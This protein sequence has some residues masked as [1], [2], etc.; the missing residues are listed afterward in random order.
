MVPAASRQAV[1]AKA[2]IAAVNGHGRLIVAVP[3]AVAGANRGIGLA[4]VSGDQCRG[5][6][7]VLGQQI[8]RLVAD[9]RA[10]PGTGRTKT[11]VLGLHMAYVDTDLTRGFDVPKTSPEQIVQR[12]LDGL[13]AGAEEVLADELTQRLKQAMT[14]ER[15]GY[16]QA[17]QA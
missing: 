13:E 4:F 6:G 12:A 2:L 1:R 8:G 9:Q 15:P 10:A 14:A 3:G 7:G 11:Q 17:Q 5:T 16:L